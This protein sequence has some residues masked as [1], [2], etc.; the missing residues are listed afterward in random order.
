MTEQYVQQQL[1]NCE[2]LSVY[3]WTTEKSVA[4]IDFMVQYRENAIP[5][6]VKAEENLQAKSLKSFYQHYKPAVSIRTSMSDYRKDDWLT[7]FP[8]YAVENYWK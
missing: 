3:Y 8:L 7:N 1:K 6:E 2:N 5:I 4:E